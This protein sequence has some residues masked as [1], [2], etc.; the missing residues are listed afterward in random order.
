MNIKEAQK[1]ATDLYHINITNKNEFQLLTDEIIYNIKN[2]LDV[3]LIQ[4]TMKNG[5]IINFTANDIV[6]PLRY[7]DIKNFY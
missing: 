3:K 6:K 7:D 2:G 1:I 5:Q 4:F